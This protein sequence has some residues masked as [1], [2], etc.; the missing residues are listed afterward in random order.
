MCR[1]KERGEE[2]EEEGGEA[3]LCGHK[4]GVVVV[5]SVSVGG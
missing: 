1:G 4:G 2:W 3:E 5:V